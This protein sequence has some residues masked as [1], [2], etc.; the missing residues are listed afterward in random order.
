MLTP[1][2]FATH[3]GVAYTTVISWI[4]KGLL[5][6]AEQFEMPFGGFVWRVP[7]DATVPDLKPGPVP[8]AQTEQGTKASK[9]ARLVKKGSDQ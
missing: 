3:H 2:Q 1:R 5:A 9:K 4:N 7:I 6:G 8:K